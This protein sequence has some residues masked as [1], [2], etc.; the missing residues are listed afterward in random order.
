MVAE[1]SCEAVCREG[2]PAFH[3]ARPRSPEPLVRVLMDGT[4]VSLPEGCLSVILSMLPDVASLGAAISAHRC[5]TTTA[6]ADESVWQPLAE[7]N[8]WRL[9]RREGESWSELYRRVH[10]G[11]ARQRLAAVGGG[12]GTNG[13]GAHVDLLCFGEGV[14]DGKWRVGS[15]LRFGERDAPCA[16]SDGLRLHVFGGWDNDEDDALASGEYAE[17]IDPTAPL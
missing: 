16:A 7:R 12:D 1:F 2:Q 5:F 13:Q 9:R 8:A 3:G 14:P 15:R 11:A 6:R 17:C 10:N 4:L